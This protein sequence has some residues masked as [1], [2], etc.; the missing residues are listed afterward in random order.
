MP[1]T[2]GIIKLPVNPCA[3][4]AAIKKAGLVASAHNNEAKVNPISPIKKARLRPNW[5]PIRPPVI[6]PAANA[7]VYPATVHWS[8]A[9]LAPNDMDIE[10]AATLTIV[11]SS[12]SMKTA[13]KTTTRE[14]SCERGLT[15]RL[16]NLNTSTVKYLYDKALLLYNIIELYCQG[17]ISI[18]Y[19][20]YNISVYAF[21]VALKYIKI[22][23]IKL[24]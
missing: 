11:A 17:N 12:N 15:N 16:F 5:S 14:I 7:S 4:R 20:Q 2:W 3:T 13:T 23:V 6:N 1:K 8:S 18:Q 24:V 10:G 19:N 22:V 9:S 21:T